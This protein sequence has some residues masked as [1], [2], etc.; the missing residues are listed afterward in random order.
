MNHPHHRFATH[1]LKSFY[2]AQLFELNN[3]GK[4]FG[5]CLRYAKDYTAAEDILQESFIKIFNKI[6]QFSFEGSFEGWVRRIVVNTAID[7]LRKQSLLY[8][9][10]DDYSKYDTIN[11]DDVT[12]S[13]S[14]QD[15][16]KLVQE[17]SPQYRLVFNMFAIEGYPHSEI[18]EILGISEGTSKSNLSRARQIL[19]EKVRTKYYF[20]NSTKEETRCLEIKKK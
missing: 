16:I 8:V 2:Q 11:Y 18:A 4:M 7:K 5:I 19:Q 14:A 1:D 9:L 3:S 12:S 13:I 20:E 17:L 15:L 6:S 10:T